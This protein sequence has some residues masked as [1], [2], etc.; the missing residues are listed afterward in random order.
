MP[1]IGASN[2]VHAWSSRSPSCNNTQWSS[3]K[4]DEAPRQGRRDHQVE[5]P[6]SRTGVTESQPRACTKVEES[7]STTTTRTKTKVTRFDAVNKQTRRSYEPGDQRSPT[8][9]IKTDAK[10]QPTSFLPRPLVRMAL[11]VVR[12]IN[13]EGVQPTTDVADTIDRLKS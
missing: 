5:R 10:R 8:I 7:T 1:N 9:P 2:N 4:Y 3:R 6:G 11:R 13:V 12:F